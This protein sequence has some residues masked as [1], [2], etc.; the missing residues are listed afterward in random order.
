MPS[1]DLFIY[2]SFHERYFYRTIF[3]EK[4]LPKCFYLRFGDQGYWL[5]WLME[6]PVSHELKERSG[7]L[8]PN[9]GTSPEEQR[10]FLIHVLSCWEDACYEYSQGFAPTNPSSNLPLFCGLQ[11]QGVCRSTDT[12]DKV[13][14]AVT[15]TQLDPNN[16]HSPT[17]GFCVILLNYELLATTWCFK[18]AWPAEAD[19]SV[20][21]F[22]AG[23][24]QERTTEKP[25]CSLNYW[26]IMQYSNKSLNCYK[27][28]LLHFL[29]RQEVY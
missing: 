21:I 24:K 19:G 26:K 1:W 13:S 10:T 8:S 3:A 7:R 16:S 27:N 17:R 12:L 25:Q 9:F 20:P 5:S 2:M 6:K 11:K 4:C 22:S 18:V 28:S 29:L 15:L 23:G 14:V